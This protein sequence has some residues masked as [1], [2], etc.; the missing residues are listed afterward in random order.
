MM[1]QRREHTKGTE[2]SSNMAKN[3]E[4]PC[5]TCPKSTSLWHFQNLKHQGNQ[6][7]NPELLT[8]DGLVR[9]PKGVLDDPPPSTMP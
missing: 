5:S 4:K 3:E 9:F 7:P 6:V 2:K 8:V 1:I